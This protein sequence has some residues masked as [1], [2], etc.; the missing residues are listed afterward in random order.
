MGLQNG[1][2]IHIH[3]TPQKQDMIWRN[4]TDLINAIAKKINAYKYLE[5]GVFNPD[6]NFNKDR[7][8]VV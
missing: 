1:Q 4:H 2:G 5:V 6:N 7:K 8:S 3:E